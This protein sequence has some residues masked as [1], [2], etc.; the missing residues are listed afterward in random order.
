MSD[1]LFKN[2]YRISSTRLKGWD[3]SKDGY[4]FVTI[5]VKKQECLFGRINKDKMICT[6]IG[7]IACKYW[8]EIP[9]HF[10][11]VRLDEY[12]V[13]PNHVH[14]IVVIDKS[15]DVEKAFNE[16]WESE[17]SDSL[18]DLSK[19]ENI[20]IEK[21]EELIGEYLYTQKLPR[22]QDIADLIDPPLKILK[23]KSIIDRIK[24][25]IEN[26]VDVFDW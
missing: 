13:M 18:K 16:F 15:D 9:E 22:E 14:G 20:P 10:P 4:Y 25:A 23:R 2:K 7:R 19:T 12:V 8:Q 5:C 11:F 21:F 26:I 17:R 24:G 3:Y 6:E 1:D